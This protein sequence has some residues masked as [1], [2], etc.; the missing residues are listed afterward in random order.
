MRQVVVSMSVSMDGFTKGPDGRFDWSAPD[1]EVFALATEE[2]RGLSAHLLGRH[3]Y[4]TMRYWEDPEVTATLDGAE[5]E[6][7]RIWNALPKIV[8]S[9]T[10]TAVEGSYRL[11][12]GGLA[13]EVERLRAEPGRA[14]SPSA[15]PRSPRTR[16]R[17]AWSRSTARGSTRCSSAAAPRSS[18]R[19]GAVRTSSC[20]RAARSAPAGSSTCATGCDRAAERARR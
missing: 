5:R 2:V 9:R 12:A 8:F 17:S 16:P 14:T 4:E 1:P 19:P 6:F 20:W 11:A 10:L 15:G 7:A 3:L 18:R 13:E